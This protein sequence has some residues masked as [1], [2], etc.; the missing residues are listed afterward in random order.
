MDFKAESADIIKFFADNIS[1]DKN[2]IFSKFSEGELK[3]MYILCALTPDGA[4]SG[5]I[6]ARA[7][8]TTGRV[9]IV[10]NGLENKGFILRTRDADDKR[11]VFVTAT[12]K[13]RAEADTLYND[14]LCCT[15]ALF[16]RLGENDTTEFVRIIKRIFTENPAATL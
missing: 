9:A 12:D 6:A 10:L 8:L 5:D 14:M 2:K 15:T 7:H 4:F 13:G 3:I 11:K 16:E 1:Y